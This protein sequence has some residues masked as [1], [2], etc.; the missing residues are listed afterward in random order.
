MT[1]C[2][3]CS[4]QLG[5][6]AAPSKRW[7]AG[8]AQ[9]ALPNVLRSLARYVAL[10]L[11]NEVEVRWSLSEGTFRRPWARVTEAAMSDEAA[12]VEASIVETKLSRAFT[13]GVDP[14][15]QARSRAHPLRV[16]LYS[17]EGVGLRD[18]ATQRL[19]G[20][21][22]VGEPSVSRRP[23]LADDRAYV[24]ACDVRLSWGEG[25][26]VPI[27]GQLVERVTATAGG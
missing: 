23:D 18:P 13:V 4:T 21:R 7:R 17:Y 1:L 6:V 11:G 27:T 12:I 5:V 20:A 2:V 10:A 26:G 3:A 15:L 8:G 16:P 24:V 22:V 9:R 19:G 25:I 14:A